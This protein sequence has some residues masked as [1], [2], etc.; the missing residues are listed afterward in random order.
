MD[1]ALQTIPPSML[2][3]DF[4]IA[5]DASWKEAEVAWDTLISAGVLPKHIKNAKIAVTI[6]R[7]GKVFGWD[8]MRSLHKIHLVEGRCEM[9][10]DSM[11]AMILERARERG[12]V[13]TPVEMTSERAA[14]KVQRQGLDPDPVVVEFTADDAKAAGLSGRAN[15]KNYPADMLWA[16]CVSR[17]GRRLFPD[18]VQGAYVHGELH[19]PAAHEEPRHDSPGARFLQRATVQQ[20]EREPGADEAE[21]PPD[22]FDQRTDDTE[23]PADWQGG[24]QP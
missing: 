4:A 16:R 5:S 17:V 7:F 23:P 22:D 20:L 18:V 6:A 21:P 13:V 2:D 3:P 12:D 19:G 15:H 9:S 24:V 10:A 1:N 14:I 11:M 8:P